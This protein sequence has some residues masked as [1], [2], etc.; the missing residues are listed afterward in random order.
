M[1][2]QVAESLDYH[3]PLIQVGTS[4]GGVLQ[5]PTDFV[6]LVSGALSVSGTTSNEFAKYWSDE[7]AAISHTTGGQLADSATI[8]SSASIAELRRRSGLTWDQLARLFGVARRS[9]HFWASGKPLNAANEERLGRVLAVIRYIDRGSA[10]ETRAALLSPLEDG[11]VPFD[12]LAREE[13]QVLA[14]R[15]GA[16]VERIELSLT[17]L[18]PEARAARMPLPPAERIAAHKDSAHRNVGRGR[19]ARSAKIKRER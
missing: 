6:I 11:V 10:R 16:G 5:R 1:S 13:Y 15:L 8:S 17:P 2:L 9:V 18:A 4:G 7:L 19:A 14:D 12:L 3:G